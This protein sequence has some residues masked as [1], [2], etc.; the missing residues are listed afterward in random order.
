MRNAQALDQLGVSMCACRQLPFSR[1]ISDAGLPKASRSTRHSFVQS[2]K[3]CASRV[4][5]VTLIY[6]LLIYAS[7]AWRLR[8]AQS[9]ARGRG[10]RVD[11]SIRKSW[12][13]G[14]ASGSIAVT[15]SVRSSMRARASANTCSRTAS[16]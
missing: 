12:R 6:G 1:A 15:S 4:G 7:S 14:I 3:G 10:L 9:H 11:G 5:K 2:I 16:S 8:N 13:S